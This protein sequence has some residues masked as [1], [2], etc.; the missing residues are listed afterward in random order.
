MCPY[1]LIFHVCYI[2]SRIPLVDDLQEHLK[3]IPHSKYD[4]K[5]TWED[6][7]WLKSKT[8]LPLI[9]KGILTGELNMILGGGGG[10]GG[11]A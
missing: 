6:I 8:D 9:L 7:K 5:L 3:G 11:V 4:T 2:F 1:I 10:G